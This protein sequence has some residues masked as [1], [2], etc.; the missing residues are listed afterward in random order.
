MLWSS[1]FPTL[2][3]ELM[4]NCTGKPLLGPFYQGSGGIISLMPRF[5]HSGVALLTNVFTLQT[6]PDFLWSI[7]VCLLRV[8]TSVYL[9]TA[10]WQGYRQV[11][12]RSF[13]TPIYTNICPS[14]LRLQGKLLLPHIFLDW[15]QSCHK[16]HVRITPV[17]FVSTNISW[18]CHLVSK[19][20]LMALPHRSASRF[21]ISLYCTETKR[22]RYSWL[23]SCQLSLETVKHKK[24]LALQWQAPINNVRMLPAAVPWSNILHAFGHLWRAPVLSW[25]P[26]CL[27]SPAGH[28]I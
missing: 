11:L 10:S 2:R 15:I 13:Y 21:D 12:S 14:R 7:S 25:W 8:I 24:C 1:T 28:W 19:D 9:I 5:F 20:R 4:I 18:I 17:C 23:T 22:I 27:L 26:T 3:F 16:L 6:G